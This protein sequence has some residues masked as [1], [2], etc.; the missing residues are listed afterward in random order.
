MPVAQIGSRSKVRSDGD[1]EFP[2]L[3]LVEDDKDDN[4]GGGDDGSFSVVGVASWPFL[5][6]KRHMLTMID[7]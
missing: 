5:S 2:P 6:V 1:D 3:S 4:V 7:A